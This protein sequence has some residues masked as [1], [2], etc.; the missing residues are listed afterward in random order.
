MMLNAIFV[1]MAFIVEINDDD[2][3]DDN[4]VVVKPQTIQY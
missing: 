1:C 3:D 2:D 4:D